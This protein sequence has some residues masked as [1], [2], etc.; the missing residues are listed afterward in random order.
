MLMLAGIR[1]IL[2]ISTAKDIPY[3][4]QLLGDGNR[5]G[6]SLRYAEQSHPR[7]IADA[8]RIGKDFIGDDTVCLML[9]DNIF[10][11]TSLPER[12]RRDAKL[13]EGAIIFAYQVKQPEHFAVLTFETLSEDGIGRVL[14]IEEKPAK[15]RSRF[16]VPG[17]YFYDN[18]VVDIAKELKPSPRGELEITDLNKVYLE[19]GQL[20]VEILG[21]GVAWLDAG[22]PESL[23]KASIFVQVVEE[24]QGMMVS[25]PEEIA[26]RL[27][28]I[29]VSQLETL[30]NE[31][32]ETTYKEY[33]IRL[34]NQENLQ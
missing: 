4:N 21:R 17:L 8:F 23:L 25:C 6:L 3:Y 34:L 12:L 15:P 16:A 11:G 33:L 10:Y 7:G 20:K 14:S 5:W 27:G 30:V 28:F 9:G 19:R 26:Y 2:V 22:T 13:T 24:R 31:M 1:D 29:S 18:E 32:G